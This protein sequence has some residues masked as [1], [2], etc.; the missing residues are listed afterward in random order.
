MSP[1]KQAMKQGQWLK[2]FC[3]EARCLSEQEVAALPDELKQSREATGKD[4]LWLEVFC[5]DGSCLG[6][7]EKAGVVPM[8]EPKPGGGLWLKLFCPDG[9]CQLRQSSELP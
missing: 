5:P 6:E 4:G 1:E 8:V 7:A 9:S 2:V 3:P